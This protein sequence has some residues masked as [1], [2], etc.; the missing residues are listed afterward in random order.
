MTR[1]CPQKLFQTAISRNLTCTRMLNDKTVNSVTCK[2][3]HM[4]A[5]RL[6]LQNLGLDWKK[7]VQMKTPA[8]NLMYFCDSQKH[9][10]Y[11]EH[12]V[13]LSSTWITNNSYVRVR[14]MGL[15]STYLNCNVKKNISYFRIRNRPSA[16]I[17]CPSSFI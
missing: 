16:Q 1:F 4:N 17:A 6:S 8:L 12:S 11:L 13:K 2:V 7:C 9:Y 3:Q 5:E 15:F 10:G 14:Q